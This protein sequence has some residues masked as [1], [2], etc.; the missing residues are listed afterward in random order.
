[1]TP[2]AIV[3]LLLPALGTAPA[4]RL[5]DMFDDADADNDSVLTF[6][7]LTAILPRATPKEFAAADLNGDGSLDYDEFELGIDKGYFERP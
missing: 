2:F 4:S 1:M 5:G 3:L 7:E 6:E